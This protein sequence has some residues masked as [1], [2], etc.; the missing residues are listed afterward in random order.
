MTDR[1]W[2]EVVEDVR[3]KGGHHKR[4]RITR[5]GRKALELADLEEEYRQRG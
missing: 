4:Y 1:G 3:S 5:L 2:V